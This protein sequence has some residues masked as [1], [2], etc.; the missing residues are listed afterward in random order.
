MPD[1]TRARLTEA[2]SR[3]PVV[4]DG[5]LDAAGLAR[6][7]DEAVTAELDYIA[8]L[9]G[10]GRIRGMGDAAAGQDDA[11]RRVVEAYRLGFLREGKSPEDAQRLAEIAAS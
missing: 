9:G 3:N 6:R 2:L 11:H 5:K 4:T 7:I 1:V 10:S 8:S